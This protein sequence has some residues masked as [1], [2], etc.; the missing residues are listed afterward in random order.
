MRL[1]VNTAAG[2]ERLAVQHDLGHLVGDQIKEGGGTG[3]GVERD[4][5][6]GCEIPQAPTVR[7]SETQ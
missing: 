6:G 2:V 3:L 1:S 5:G 4:L 7:S